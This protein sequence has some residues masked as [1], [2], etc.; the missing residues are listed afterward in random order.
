MENKVEGTS[1][2][3]F[4]IVQKIIDLVRGTDISLKIIGGGEEIIVNTPYL[5]LP[6]DTPVMV[7]DTKR[8]WT[9]RY[10]SKGNKAYLNGYKS[11]SIKLDNPWKYIIPFSQFDPNNIE[12]SLKHDIVP[13][14][15]K[16]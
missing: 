13:Q 4:K 11:N 5:Y 3:N 15:L 7:S 1:S 10:Y 16:Q 12:E 2:D 14:K 6:V 8:D 9:L